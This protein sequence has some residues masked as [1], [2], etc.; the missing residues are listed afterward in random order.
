MNPH[1]IE[2]QIRD[3]ADEHSVEEAHD[4]AE[5][6]CRREAYNSITAGT[7]EGQFTIK[8]G[9]RTLQVTCNRR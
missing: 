5:L 2:D 6:T 4:R 7:L 3:A 9:I 8:I 1:V